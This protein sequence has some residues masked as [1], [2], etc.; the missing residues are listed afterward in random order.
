MDTFG[1]TNLFPSFSSRNLSK[2]ELEQIIKEAVAREH[3]MRFVKEVQY[4]K[5]GVEVTLDSGEVIEVEI[6]WQEFVLR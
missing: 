3:P 5:D 6:D 1:I 2:K 4:T